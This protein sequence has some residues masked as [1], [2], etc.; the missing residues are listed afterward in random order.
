LLCMYMDVDEEAV[1]YGVSGMCLCNFM[2]V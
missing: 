1:L 2:Y